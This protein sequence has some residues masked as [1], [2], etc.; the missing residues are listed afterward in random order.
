MMILGKI[1]RV[2]DMKK[3]HYVSLKNY[4][5]LSESMLEEPNESKLGFS[6]NENIT[7]VPLNVV[8]FIW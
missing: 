5:E 3:P 7:K 6:L 1:C 2:R 8:S 4:Y